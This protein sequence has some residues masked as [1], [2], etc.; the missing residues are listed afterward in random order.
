M[1]QK[2]DIVGSAKDITNEAES[3]VKV[4]SSIILTNASGISGEFVDKYGWDIKELID[5]ADSFDS[6]LI[7][8]TKNSNIIPVEFYEK[9]VN[10]KKRED[11]L[12]FMVIKFSNI[13][14]SDEFVIPGG[15]FMDENG[16]TVSKIFSLAD[17]FNFDVAMKTRSSGK[18]LKLRLKTTE[19]KIVYDEDDFDNSNGGVFTETGELPF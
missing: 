5:F 18:I 6:D 19:N 3:I 8:V 15:I 4:P 11:A 13:R 2:K 17:A 9:D 10:E 12:S 7:M 14:L 16:W 1:N